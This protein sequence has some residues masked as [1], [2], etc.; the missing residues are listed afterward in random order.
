MGKCWMFEETGEVRQAKRGEWI[1]S[2][3]MNFINK[4]SINRTAVEHHILKLTE[5]SPNPLEP[6][7]E[8]YSDLRWYFANCKSRHDFRSEAEWEMWRVI[9]KCVETVGREL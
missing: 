2:P 5:Y 4:C 3:K 8:I 6:I 7:R 1:Y 9:K